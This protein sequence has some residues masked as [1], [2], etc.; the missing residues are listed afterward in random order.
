MSDPPSPSKLALA[1]EGSGVGCRNGDE[2]EWRVASGE[3]RIFLTI[4]I[5]EIIE[6]TE[7]KRGN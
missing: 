3:C 6:I 2:A 7:T 4:E 1:D 5:S